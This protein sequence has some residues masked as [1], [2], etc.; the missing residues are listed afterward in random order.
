MLAAVV[1]FVLWTG[2]LL[3]GIGAASLG[4]HVYGCHITEGGDGGCP[5]LAAIAGLTLIAA[6]GAPLFL[7]AI[8]GCLLLGGIVFLFG[9]K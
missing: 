3:F 1:I 9:R 7:G 2:C 5:T 4:S 8:L 6:F